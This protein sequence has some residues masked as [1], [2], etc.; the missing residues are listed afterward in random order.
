[1]NRIVVL[2]S[3]LFGYLFLALSVL[4]TVETLARKL[5]NMSLQGADELGGYALAVGSSIAFAIALLGRS[6]IRIDLVHRLLPT[7]ARALLNWLSYLLMTLFALLLAWVCWTV[8]VDTLAYR[9]TAPTPWATPLIYPQSVWYAA[10]ALFALV[11]VIMTLRASYLLLRGRLQALDREFEPKGA[12]E[13]LK[14]ELEDVT[15]R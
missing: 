7:T 12:L 5:F 3:N 8:V 2:A 9:S 10:L 6:H 13:E 4:V 15:R 1:M 11:A 14:E